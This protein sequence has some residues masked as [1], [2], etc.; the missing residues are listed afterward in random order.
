MATIV[1]I[2]LKD[3][4]N[5][6]LFGSFMYS[7]MRLFKLIKGPPKIQEIL[8]QNCSK[9]DAIF[10]T[11]ITKKR[12]DIPDFSYDVVKC[13]SCKEYNIVDKGPKIE[14]YNYSGYEIIEQLKKDEYTIEKANQRLEQIKHWRK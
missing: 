13:K 10:E 3:E 7:S 8:S 6:W 14:Q 11:Y 5:R 4:L 2:D 12:N 9:C 1:S